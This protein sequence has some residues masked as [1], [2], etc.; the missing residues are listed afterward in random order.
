MWDEEYDLV[1]VGSGLAGLS[2]AIEGASAG[3]SVVV[4]EKRRIV[5]GNTRLAAGEFSAP[6][7]KLNLHQKLGLPPDDPDIF[8]EDI[9][10][11]GDRVQDPELVRVLAYGAAEA[12]N[13]LLDLGLE[14]NPVLTKPGG[15]SSFRCHSIKGGGKAIVE[16]LLQRANGKGVKVMTE[17]KLA[18]LVRE[19][20]F[21]GRVLGAKVET[22]EGEILIG[23]RKGVILAAGGFSA[24]IPF[25]MKY[26]HS[27]G[28]EMRTTN[29]PEATGEAIRIAQSIGADVVHMDYIQLYPFS[30]PETGVLD[31]AALIPF[32]GPA[33][34][35]IYVS[36]EGRR[37]VNELERRDVCARRQLE[38]GIKPTYS[39]ASSDMLQRC[40]FSA[41]E[42]ERMV[43]KGRLVK[44]QSI[45][46]LA[47][48][49][50]LPPQELSAAVRKHNEFVE[51]GRDEEFGK[52]IGPEMMKMEKPPFFGL[53][54][55]PAV[56]HTMGGLRI[57]KRA[58]V[59]DLWG[60]PIPGLLAAGEIAGGIHGANRLGGCAL[61]DCVV[62]GRIAALTALSL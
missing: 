59:L 34:G 48:K 38:L 20:P 11:G 3:A 29:H 19:R 43:E 53:A 9:L 39:I 35:L 15:H 2:A 1:V 4:L 47:A 8:K 27:L 37:F 24:D 16:T 26:N 60:E 30:H 56:H 54:Q 40:G 23:A 14:L 21:G 42:L 36:R 61:P 45:E 62:F 52:P 28:P 57:N 44:A 46:E 58:Q 50:G 6:A 41:D 13:W 18:D 51:E 31:R 25:R 33:F 5:G 12:L 22:R 10:R 17:H 49:L 32:R 55:W 7:D